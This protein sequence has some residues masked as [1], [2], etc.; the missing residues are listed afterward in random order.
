MAD[1][2]NMQNFNNSFFADTMAIFCKAYI[3]IG[4]RDSFFFLH[5]ISLRKW[6]AC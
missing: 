4:D 2:I 1:N 5:I 3:V 6:F